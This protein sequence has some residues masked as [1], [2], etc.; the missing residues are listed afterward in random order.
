V[1]SASSDALSVNRLSPLILRAALAMLALTVAAISLGLPGGVGPE[2]FLALSRDDWEELRAI[3]DAWQRLAVFGIGAVDI[4]LRLVAAAYFLVDTAVFVPFYGVLFLAIASRIAASSLSA[5]ARSVKAAASLIGL[6][7]TLLMAVD[8]VE[9]ASGLAKLRLL[10]ASPW[11]VFAAAALSVAAGFV[12]W[13][14]WTLGDDVR[15]RLAAIKAYR[16][17]AGRGFALVCVIAAVASLALT[18]MASYQPFFIVVLRIGSI[19]HTLKQL[20][21]FFDLLLMAW[22]ALL[23]LFRQSSDKQGRV[24]LRRGLADIVLRTRYV[25]A[26]LGALIGLTIV[27]DQCR[28][29]AIGVADGLAAWG[30]AWVA[31][32]VMLVS[33]I[34]V[35]AMSFSSWLWVRLACRMPAATSRSEALPD[36]VD[37]TLQEAARA[38]ARTLGLV[39]LF[40]TAVMSAMAARDAMWA[41]AERSGRPVLAPLVLLLFGAASVVGG[42]GFLRGRERSAGAGDGPPERYYNDP[43][44]DANWMETFDGAKYRFMWRKGPGP[45]ALPISALLLAVILRCVSALAQPTVPFAYP[46][47]LFTLVMWMGFFGWLSLKEQRE[48]RP[49]VLLLVVLVGVE[50]FAGFADNHVVRIADQF[51]G[52][53]LSAPSVQVLGALLLMIVVVI[54]ATLV[55]RGTSRAQEGRRG[56][57]SW[58]W[59]LAGAAVV[60]L[61]I[62]LAVDRLPADAETGLRPPQRPTITVAFTRWMDS[63]WTIRATLSERPR[64]FFV[65]SEG[66]GIRAA[67]WTARVLQE[68]AAHEP[69]FDARTFMVSGVSGGALGAAVYVA[70]RRLD[71][72]GKTLAACID[73]FGRTDILTPMVGAWLFEDG[74]AR[75][76]PTK[77]CRRPGCGF[78]SRGLWFEQSLER[79][80][81][82]LAKGIAQGAST[83]SAHVPHLFLN[84][85][86]VESGDR[87]IASSVDANWDAEAAYDFADARDQLDFVKRDKGDTPDMPLSAAAHNASRFPYVNAIG[88]LKSKNEKQTD[89]H[90]ADGGYFDNSG[91]Q[92]TA[93]V[94]SAFRRWVDQQRCVAP[95]GACDERVNWLQGLRPTVIVIQNGLSDDCKRDEPSQRVGCLRT[96]WRLDMGPGDRD[97]YLPEKPREA[98]SW[99]L[100]VDAVG[101][102]VTVVNVAGT[103]ANGRRA[104]ALLKRACSAFPVTGGD[105]VVRLAQRADGL[106]YPLGWYLSPTARSALDGK[107][108]DEVALAA[109]RLWE[110]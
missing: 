8:V 7:T 72:S 38:A 35:W 9:N 59:T 10:G 45:V 39:P 92:T 80:N 2:R 58:G 85:T 3:N 79:G 40:V 84:S 25:L 43:R 77:Q 88:T 34:A 41:A 100:Y 67:Y 96:Q 63:L 70:C 105:C 42:I 23:W 13:R 20:L 47:I 64:V 55:A 48:A 83:A 95:A 54:A 69:T 74:L 109:P 106:L 21:L 71:S 110:K 81:P 101:P 76:L 103:G 61:G 53:R 16:G 99:K 50:G 87:A 24:A 66:G 17:P 27:S 107:A 18:L 73:E 33:V 52:G 94:L 78:M 51:G 12:I 14:W 6:A 49:W 44:L 37:S 65:S 5:E 30:S 22:V 19:S 1:T 93:D 102:L 36:A 11:L 29:V 82:E 108:R 98:D 32:L 26:A 104:E 15:K 75:V 86:W 57:V 89:G 91:A 31:T 60:A 4:R 68:L 28:D 62:M 97:E 90:L 56:F 46:V